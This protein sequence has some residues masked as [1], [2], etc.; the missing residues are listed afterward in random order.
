MM[1]QSSRA[2]AIIVSEKRLILA[3]FSREFWA[4]LYHLRPD[5]PLPV[6]DTPHP[7]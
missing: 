5:S 1:P 6:I 7:G 3:T 4:V 2:T